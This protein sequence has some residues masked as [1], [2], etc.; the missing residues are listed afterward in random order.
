VT[1]WGAV[2]RHDGVRLSGGGDDSKC[3]ALMIKGVRPI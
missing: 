1:W 2:R 3:C